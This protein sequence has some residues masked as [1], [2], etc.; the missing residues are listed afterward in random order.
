MIRTVRPHWLFE[1]SPAPYIAKIDMPRHRGEDGITLLET[2]CLISAMRTVHA[3][4]VLEIGTYRGWT[5]RNLA[6]NVQDGGKVWTVDIAPRDFDAGLLPIE[7]VQADSRCWYEGPE[8]FD[9]VFIDGAHDYDSIALDTAM[10]RSRSPKAIFWHDFGH[11][12]YPD[13]SRFLADLTSGTGMDLFHIADTTL[14]GW[15]TAF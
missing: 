15:F 6:R 9:F 5:T 7:R 14:V 11:P 4:T 12:G 8:R 13:V 1:L 10:V 2:F 3:Q